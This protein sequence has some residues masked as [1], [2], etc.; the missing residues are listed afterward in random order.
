MTGKAI[1]AASDADIIAGMVAGI[2]VV[3]LSLDRL[4]DTHECIDSILAQD[5]P[6][7]RL[8]VL[9]QGSEPATVAS[10]RQ[11]SLADSF[12]FVEVGRIGVAAGR[13]RGYRMGKAPLI[14]A[15]DNDAV[16]SDAGVLTRIG[17][18]FAADAR[19][20]VL[21][22][23]VHDYARGGPDVGSWGYP[24]PVASHFKQEF[25]AA[26]FCGAGHAVSRAAFT[27]SPGYDE[28]LFFFGE[29]L[30]LSWS[31]ISLGYEIRYVPEVAVRHKSSQERRIS[32]AEGRYYYNV[33]NMLY[34]QRK[35]WHDPWMLLEYLLGYLIKGLG[36]GL[37]RATLKGVR[38]GLRMQARGEGAAVLDEAARAYVFAHEYAP[39]GSAWRRFRREVVLRLS[40]RQR[41]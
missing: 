5:H 7:V 27:A 11:R 35:Y 40:P 41:R 4:H 25:L 20:G 37:F 16:L 18:R 31:L 29:E 39:R 33:R 3:V 21:A 6:Q 28:Q 10:L 19:L 9:D 24:W 30:D 2:D 26:R 8:W 13:N 32:W 22:F 12:A 36:N 23:A 1:D 15:L 14:V 34:L 17:Q 38:D